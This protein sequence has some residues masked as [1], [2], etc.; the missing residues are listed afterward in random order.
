MIVYLSDPTNS[1]RELLELINK[2]SKV[3]GYKINT[4]QSVAFFYSKDKHVKKKIREMIPF[5]IV[6]NNI[7]YIGVTLTKQVKD[8]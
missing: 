3:A 4:N 8:L 1:T 2:F 5:T 6:I 7:K